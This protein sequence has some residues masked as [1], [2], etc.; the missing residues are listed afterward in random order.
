VTSIA[1]LAQVNKVVESLLCVNGSL[2]E[3]GGAAAL[4]TEL[5]H[6]RNKQQFRFIGQRGATARFVAP[7]QVYRYEM[8]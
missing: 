4:R 5:F 8:V 3:Q 2:L 6:Y 7:G 1:V